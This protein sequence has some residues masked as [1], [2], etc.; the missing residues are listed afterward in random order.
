MQADLYTMTPAPNNLAKYVRSIIY[1]NQT[2]NIDVSSH[3]NSTGCMYLGWLVDGNCHVMHDYGARTLNEGSW[4]LS[5]QILNNNIEMQYNGP[6][7]HILFELK[8]L[9]AFQLFNIKG[10]NC[11]NQCLAPSEISEQLS[12]FCNEISDASQNLALTDLD[13]RIKHIT[14]R[15]VQRTSKPYAVPSYLEDSLEK[16]DACSGTIRINELATEINIS[17]RQ[18]NRTFKEYVG[19]SPKFYAKVLQMNQALHAMMTNDQHYLTQIAQASGFYDQ[20]HLI[21]VMQDFFSSSPADF[22][23]S[24]EHVLLTFLARSRSD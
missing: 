15:F 21:H 2:E 7:K 18:L 17:S 24:D 8:P 9:G 22:I 10:I 14:E 13:S 11:L 12:Q 1:T 3:A 4:H 19:L 23:N 5:G 16:L 20:S 6:F